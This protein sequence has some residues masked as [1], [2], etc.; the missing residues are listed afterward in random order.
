MIKNTFAVITGIIVGGL[1][2]MGII[3]ISPTIIPPPAGVDVTNMESLTEA[4][5]LFGI[6]HFIFP[7]LAHAIGTFTGSF[8]TARTATRHH[9]MLAFTVGVFFL[10]GGIANAFLLP[11]PGWFII[12]DLVAAYLPMAWLGGQLAH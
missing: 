7:F 12:L 6:K 11:A 9:M 2:N 10:L 5:H 3:M 8:L 4:M 1:V